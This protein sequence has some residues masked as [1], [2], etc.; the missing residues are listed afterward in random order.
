MREARALDRPG[1]TFGRIRSHKAMYL[2]RLLLK[3]DA[4]Y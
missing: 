2:E 4:D 3:T 1:Y